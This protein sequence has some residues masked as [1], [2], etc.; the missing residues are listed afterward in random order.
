M[1]ALNPIN[2]SYW[3][4]KLCESNYSKLLCL[5][6]DLANIPESN[7]VVAYADGKPSLHLR[8][9]RRAPY[10]LTLELTYCFDQGLEAF[11]PAVKIRVY[12]DARAAEVLSDHCRPFVLDALKSNRSGREVLDYK[13]SLNYFLYKW[14][15]HCLKNHYRFSITRSAHERCLALE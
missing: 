10:T 6:P 8:L 11:E 1:S 9:I 14:L 4:E 5:V 13:W 15:D 7:R 2:K 12:L 3:L